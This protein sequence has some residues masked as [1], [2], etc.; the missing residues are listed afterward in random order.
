[1]NPV[2][3]MFY[4]TGSLFYGSSWSDW[5]PLFAEK[6]GLTPSYLVLETLID[7]IFH[8]NVLFKFLCILYKFSIQLTPLFINLRSFWP[9]IS[10]KT[11]DLIRFN[12]FSC[13]EPSYWKF[14]AVAPT[15]HSWGCRPYSAESGDLTQMR[16][17]TLHSWGC[18]PYSAERGD[19]TQMRDWNVI[20]YS[21]HMALEQDIHFQWFNCIPPCLV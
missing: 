20:L 11:L 4:L 7:L 10:T 2:L 6:F 3:G 14:G 12:F 17:E 1:M 9:I 5:P 15:L 18:R 8:Q 19:L 16:V 21:H 13:A